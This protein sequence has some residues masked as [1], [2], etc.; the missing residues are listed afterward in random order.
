MCWKYMDIH[1]TME[2]RFRLI[3][4]GPLVLTAT[5]QDATWRRSEMYCTKM[6]SLLF[7]LRL[8]WTALIPWSIKVLKG[9][10]VLIPKALPPPRGYPITQVGIRRKV[11]L[12]RDRSQG[13]RDH[14]IALFVANRDG[15]QQH[16]SFVSSSRVP[17]SWHR[18]L[19]GIFSATC[20]WNLQST[21][22][23]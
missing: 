21:S 17:R 5:V 19:T 10:N 1:D 2:E 13:R 3:R 9:R 16:D 22:P 11:S 7:L 4:V 6:S 15:T 18:Y 20:I 14:L 8:M 23:F 12:K